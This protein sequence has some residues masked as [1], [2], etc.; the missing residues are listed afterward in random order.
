MRTKT[1]VRRPKLCRSPLLVK[2]LSTR[3]PVLEMSND[4]G[5]DASGSGSKSEEGERLTVNSHDEMDGRGGSGDNLGPSRVS[6]D[7]DWFEGETCIKCDEVGQ[8]LVCSVSDCPVA[9]HEKCLPFK[10]RLDDVGNFRCPY[11]W[12]KQA[13]EKK[14]ELRKEVMLAKKALSD[15]INFKVVED[16]QE[17]MKDGK[18]KENGVN[19]SPLDCC[20]HERGVEDEE[21][22]EPSN[23]CCIEEDILVNVSLHMP[24]EGTVT[25]DM[26]KDKQATMEKEE[27]AHPEAAENTVLTSKDSGLKMPAPADDSDMSEASDSDTQAPLEQG[28]LTKQRSKMKVGGKNVDPSKKSSPQI[29]KTLERRAKNQS[30]KEITYKEPGKSPESSYQI[31][32][33][34][35]KRKRARW[36]QEEEDILT[37]GVQ[38]FSSNVNVNFPWRKVLEFG[39][40]VFNSNRTSTDLKDK[41][42]KILAKGSAEGKNALL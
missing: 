38:K 33:Y 16:D 15:F 31:N 36:T 13:V 20:D 35:E 1:L 41:W 9:V 18:A 8:M 34:N 6:M 3:L 19:M 23:T 14:Q 2:P 25:A 22:A 27:Q 24:T 42:R 7:G 39:H 30:K 37:E 4:N 26:S 12:F 21:R 10:P 17:N 40:G 29:R 5:E 32:V 28:T 11:C